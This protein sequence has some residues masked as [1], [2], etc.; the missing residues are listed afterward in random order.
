VT[1]RAISIV[2]CGVIGEKRACAIPPSCRVVA[3]HD[4]VRDRAVRVASLVGDAMVA[5]DAQAAID[6]AGAGGL[7]LVATTHDALA[8][9]ACRAADSGCHVL[10]EKPG[11]RNAAE[12]RR[13][14]A[15]AEQR[16]VVVRVG[17]NHRFH[18]S[19]LECRAALMADEQP[20]FLV[21]GRYG[22]GGRIG[23]ATEWRAD[24]AVSGG[25][26]LLDQGVHLIDL[27][28]FLAG[29]CTLA[30]S[31]LSTLYWDMSVE[32]NAFVHLRLAQGDAWLHASWT[33]WRNIF[34]VELSTRTT[35]YELRGL[36]GSYGA[37]TL[38]TSRLRPSLGPPDVFA[39]E[40]PPGDT[41]WSDEFEDVVAA[42]DG[43]PAIGCSVEEA[44]TTLDIVDGAYRA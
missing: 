26:E 40:W 44:I 42:I 31:A 24:R 29:P 10:V 11:A 2:G 30:Y 17:F 4:V 34:S 14:Q 12:L 18:P 13:V 15:V 7:V 25:G 33:E 36:G 3:V 23:Y 19:V 28:Q 8:D 32:D 37:E 21:R 43:R 39:R 6:A 22:H 20:V 27:V 9:I 41:S 1:G 16:G 35:K 5:D 38:I